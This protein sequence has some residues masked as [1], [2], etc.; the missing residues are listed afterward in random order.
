VT[1]SCPTG[2]A[3]DSRHRGVG[4]LRKEELKDGRK[5]KPDGGHKENRFRAQVPDLTERISQLSDGV[6]TIKWKQQIERQ[7]EEEAHPSFGH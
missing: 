5:D 4:E 6:M 2:S 1:G 3:C 7:D